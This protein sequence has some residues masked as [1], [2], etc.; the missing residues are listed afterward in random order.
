MALC[1]SQKYINGFVKDTYYRCDTAPA[2]LIYR[3][4]DLSESAFVRGHFHKVPPYDHEQL[5]AFGPP[6]EVNRTRGWVR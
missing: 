6:I 5:R 1:T 3:R 4:G 2:R